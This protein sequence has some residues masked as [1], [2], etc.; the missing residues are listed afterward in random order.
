MT[1]YLGI[2]VEIIFFEH[3]SEIHFSPLQ[4]SSSLA[5]ISQAILTRI[6][7]V[8]ENATAQVQEKWE[9][10]TMEDIKD[11]IMNA[12]GNITSGFE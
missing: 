1:T 11:Q 8:G 10:A 5:D 2:Q 7:E 9:N 3:F 6:T 4:E 12:L